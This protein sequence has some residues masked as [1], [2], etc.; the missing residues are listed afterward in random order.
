[1]QGYMEKAMREAKQQTSW[2]ANNKEFEDAL[3]GFIDQTLAHAPFLEE[4]E[5]FVASVKDA[6]RVNSL[7]QTLLKHTAPGVPD[8][9]QGTELWDLSLVDPDNR[10]PVDYQV[11]CQ[12]L[13]EIRSLSVAQVMERME[14]GLPKLW[15]IHHAL[16]LRRQHPEWFGAESGYRA[17]KATGTKKL[18]VLAYLRGDSVITVVPR[19]VVTLAGKW[20]NTAIALPKGQWKNRLTGE[21]VEGGKAAVEGLLQEFPVALL[22]RDE[23]GRI[24]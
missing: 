12:A 5:Q 13:H 10:R 21:R 16:C 11:R 17:L 23:S 14:D 15:T 20:A 18:H 9:Y 4:L 7:A 8:L 6:G 22:V 1:M 24:N 19:L 3:R 2:V